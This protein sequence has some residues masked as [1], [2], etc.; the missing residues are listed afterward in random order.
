MT[1]VGGIDLPDERFDGL[2]VG[3]PGTKK[4]AI[5]TR[6]SVRIASLDGLCKN[7]ARTS[8]VTSDRAVRTKEL[9]TRPQ[10]VFAARTRAT[11]CSLSNRGLRRIAAVVLDVRAHHTSTN[12]SRDGF[13][14]LFRART[15][16]RLEIGGDRK[17]TC[18]SNGPHAIQHG[19]PCSQQLLIRE[20]QR[21]SHACTRSG[22]SGKAAGR[23]HQR[24]TNVPSVGHQKDG[25][26]SVQLLEP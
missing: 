17:W 16:A 3:S 8:Q 25:L 12:R 6:L 23:E 10:R 9:P 1:T 14:N 7:I 19:L 2:G 4:N 24:T 20:S 26:G 18:R 11:A 22:D 21:E 15:V 5:R 13:S